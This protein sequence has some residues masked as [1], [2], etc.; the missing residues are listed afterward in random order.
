MEMKKPIKKVG[1]AVGSTKDSVPNVILRKRSM[2]NED[3]VGEK[4]S[5]VRIKPNLSLKMGNGQVAAQGA[6]VNGCARGRAGE[7][8]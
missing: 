7:W 4:P 6:T 5:S 2:F 3:N 1:K 8:L